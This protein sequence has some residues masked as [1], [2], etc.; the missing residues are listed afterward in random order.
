MNSTHVMLLIHS[1]SFATLFFKIKICDSASR[2]RTRIVKE[3][4]LDISIKNVYLL[5]DQPW[6]EAWTSNI[7]QYININSIYINISI[8]ISIIN[9][10][11]YLADQPWWEAWTSSREVFLRNK[12]RRLRVDTPLS[13]S[14]NIYNIYMTFKTAQMLTNH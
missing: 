9:I 1:S 4:R 12:D 7:Y 8:S 11:I 6:W 5:A 3:D 14:V 10:Y 2:F 13:R